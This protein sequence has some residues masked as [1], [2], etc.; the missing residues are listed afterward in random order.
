VLAFASHPALQALGSTVLVGVGVAWP[1]ALFV[2]PAI[3]SL[4]GDKSHA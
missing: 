4:G 2:S 3:L 1:V